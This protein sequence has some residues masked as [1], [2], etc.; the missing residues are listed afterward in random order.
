MPQLRSN[1]LQH[2]AF[3]SL[4]LFL[5][6][7]SA[8]TAALPDLEWV[9]FDLP[10]SLIT[11]PIPE[12][13]AELLAVAGYPDDD[14]RL[15][16][17][18][19]WQQ[20]DPAL[21]GDGPYPTIL[22][23]HGSGG[24]WSNDH[25]GNG[26]SNQF[27][28]WLEVLPERGYAVLCVDSYNPRG[29]PGDFRGRYPTADPV[30]DDSVCSPNYERPKDVIASLTYLASLPQVDTAHIGVLGFS[31]GSQTGLNAILDP[32]VDLSPYRVSY[33]NDTELEVAS[34]VRIPDEVP[35]PKVCAFYY[36]GGSH[37]GYHGQASSITAGRYMP[38]RR[39]KVLMF[40]G[41]E[42]SLLG[43]DDPNADPLTG[44]LYP[45]KM[46]ESSA[47]Q[48]IAEGIENPFVEHLIFDY[49]EHSFDGET[50][51]PPQN[52]NDINL[53]A[54][55]EKAKRL[56]RDEVLKWFDFLLKPSALTI[57]EDEEDPD[58]FELLWEGHNQLSYQLMSSETLTGWVPLGDT[59]I[60]S[61]VSESA[62]VIPIPMG[63]EFF[64]LEYAPV[65]PPIDDP[66][67]GGFFRDY[68]EFSY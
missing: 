66:D 64:T 31:H 27:D 61:D 46:V 53:E 11:A 4:T 25:I 17:I 40:H 29:I 63:K 45:I 37:F 30:H 43:V 58:Q 22:V 51:Q 28:D 56:A 44:N 47:L 1:H 38:D 49:A 16:L 35:F 57:Q 62:V 24:L 33:D 14:D 32:S 23:L 59:V 9:F 55:D 60:G 20:P 54:I 65:P 42:D 5:A 13:T 67:N 6:S 10:P 52:W 7:C 36:P 68:S 39:T 15:T 8:L 26:T 2:R 3:R 12:P 48:A 18:A 41:T 50:I 34:P 21:F 19:V